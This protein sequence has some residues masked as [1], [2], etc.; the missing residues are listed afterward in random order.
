MKYQVICN[1][2]DIYAVEA[3]GQDDYPTFATRDEAESKMAECVNSWPADAP[4]RNE[5]CVVET[6]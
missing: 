5:Y 1:D 6:H 4:V 3:Y 2:E